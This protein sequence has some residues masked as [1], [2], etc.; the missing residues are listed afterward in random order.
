M[1]NKFIG[2]WLELAGERKACA[3]RRYRYGE[4]LLVAYRA[5]E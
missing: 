5:L 4:G 3:N 1:G 2:A